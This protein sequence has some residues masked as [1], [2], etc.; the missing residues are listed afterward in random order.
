MA[1]GGNIELQQALFHLK[2]VLF[3]C[4]NDSLNDFQPCLLELYSTLKYGA[5]IAGTLADI[6]EFT[7]LTL[8]GKV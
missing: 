6:L 2:V 4:F 5:E 8:C 1:E 7:F 3:P